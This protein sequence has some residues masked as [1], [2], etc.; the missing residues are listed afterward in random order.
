MEKRYRFIAKNVVFLIFAYV[1]TLNCTPLKS[2]DPNVCPRRVTISSHSVNQTQWIIECCPDFFNQ[3]GKCQ[4]CPAGK[5]G[6][7]CSLSCMPNYYGVQCKTQCNCTDNKKCD[8]IHGCVCK[9]G[10]TGSECSNAC[11]SGTYGVNCSKKCLCEHNAECYPV[12]GDC[13]CSAGWFG[14][15]CTKACQSG[16][17]GVNCSEECFCAHDVECDP[18]TGDCFCPAGRFGPH[19]TKE[20]PIGKFGKNCSEICACSDVEQCDVLTGEC[21]QCNPE[22]DKG[23]CNSHKVEVNN[24]NSGQ[25]SYKSKDTVIVYILM[26]AALIGLVCVVTMV[27]KV[28]ERL[29]R[30]VQK[31]KQ[32]TSKPRLK[33]RKAKRRRSLTQTQNAQTGLY[34]VDTDMIMFQPEIEEDLY[35]EIEDINEVESDRN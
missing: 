24:L 15:H 30:Q 25:N 10:F 17:Y 5:Y 12:T 19:C 18:A 7:D 33:R 13:L 4:A 2:T 8:P 26:V 11:T 27:V 6:K 21:I 35:C 16:R 3:N 23:E 14:D 1:D 20:C 22:S 32:D 34:I 9:T 28:K 31:P 29:C